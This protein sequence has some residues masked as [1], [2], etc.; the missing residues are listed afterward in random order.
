MPSSASVVLRTENKDEF[1]KLLNELNQEIK[2]IGFVEQMY[3]EEVADL[4]WDIIRLRRLKVAT[5]NNVFETALTIILRQILFRP[6][7]LQPKLS[8]GVEQLAH[9]WFFDEDV[10]DRVS[11][12]LKE[13]G[14]DESSIVAE[15]Y[16]FRID[17]LEKLDRSLTLAVA[18]R[19]KALR[20][21]AEFRE[22]LAMRLRQST[23]RMV[24]VDNRPSSEYQLPK[25]EHG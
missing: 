2:P 13:V 7:G 25:I 5:I 20:M 6:T 21:I 19:D 9:D 12:L 23:E 17:D 1:D 18:R 16:R 24:T 11:G 3:V 15:A 4:A 14:L 8:E 10:R 22:R